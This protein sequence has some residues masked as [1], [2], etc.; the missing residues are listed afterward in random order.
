LHFDTKLDACQLFFY[1]VTFDKIYI[2]CRLII[3]W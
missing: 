1:V 3:L 2:I